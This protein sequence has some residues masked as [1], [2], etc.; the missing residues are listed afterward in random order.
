MNGH[1]KSWSEE[2]IK[3]LKKHW[4]KDGSA[5]VAKVLCRTTCAVQ[6]KTKQLSLHRIFFGDR[7]NSQSHNL[8]K[9]YNMTIEDYDKL[10]K[11]QN[12]V[13]AVCGKK[14]TNVNQYGIKRLGVDHDHKTNQVRGLLCLKCNSMLGYGDD[15]ISIFLSAATYLQ[16]Q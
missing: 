2:D 7:H 10:L 11:Q 5:K 8:R 1:G 12:Y 4:P 6:A 15:D 13:C 16:Q 14:E 3:Y 9:R